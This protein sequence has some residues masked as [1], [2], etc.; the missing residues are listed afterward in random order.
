MTIVAAKLFITAALTLFQWLLLIS[1][2]RAVSETRKKREVSGANAF[3]YTAVIVVYALPTVIY[4]ALT[5]AV[6]WVL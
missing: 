3:F 5:I 1:V 6:W 2:R 4:V